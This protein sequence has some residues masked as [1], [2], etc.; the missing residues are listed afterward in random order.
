MF[1]GIVE[2]SVGVLE[3]TD[4]G[5]TL[6]RP[7]I[8]DDLKIGNSISV[9][10]V[11]L[12]IVSFDA[13]SMRF[14]IVQETWD[15][16]NLGKLKKGDHVNVERSLS[17]S[18]RFEGHVVQGHV[19]GVAEVTAVRDVVPQGKEVTARIP[20]DLL[21]CFVPKGAV[22]LNGVSLTIA[23]LEGDLCTIALIPHT[24]EVTTFGTAKIGDL[25]NVETDVFLRAMRQYKVLGSQP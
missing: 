11:C 12:S 20:N 15:R 4:T 23:K 17:A 18:G 1:T 2:G 6:E 14:Q 16:T 24:L 5:L 22:A 9:S 13:S 7:A 25:L 8:F 19:E 3:K 21:P 10:G